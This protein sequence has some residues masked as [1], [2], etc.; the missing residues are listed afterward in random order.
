M[1]VIF[2]LVLVLLLAGLGY[3]VG[4]L[5]RPGTQLV[6]ETKCHGESAIPIGTTT[7]G[8]R[9]VVAEGTPSLDENDLALALLDRRD[10][11]VH[12]R[13]PMPKYPV[14]KFIYV[15]QPKQLVP[16]T[17]QVLL[18]RI[19][20]ASPEGP[21]RVVVWDL[22]RQ[23]EV[24]S[25]T[26]PPRAGLLYQVKASDRYVVGLATAREHNNV[27]IWDR[28]THALHATLR[29]DYSHL[30]DPYFDPTGQRLA[31][32]RFDQ[33]S[34]SEPYRVVIVKLADGKEFQ[35]I[36]GTILSY[37]WL[38]DRPAL[39][40]VRVDSRASPLV[41]DSPL[42]WERFE[43]NG[44]EFA[45]AA[46]PISLARGPSR[47][48]CHEQFAVQST[49]TQFLPWRVWFE[50]NAPSWLVVRVNAL[51]PYRDTFHLHDLETSHYR[52]EID[53]PDRWFDPLIH[54][55]A[56]E[57]TVRD[58]STIYHYR[59]GVGTEW[60]P[61]A[62]AASGAALGLLLTLRRRRRTVAAAAPPPPGSPGS[63]LP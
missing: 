21:A 6:W 61:W 5:L 30:A 12:S 15:T 46:G 43:W 42:V 23:E 45:L 24:D 3:G 33:R 19:R 28:S 34:R 52:H 48:V 50:A 63:P 7:C 26:S 55:D 1:R 59:T 8:T 16:G 49:S 2:S 58:Q 35:H 4:V 9:I 17:N 13:Q 31:F 14:A 53:M 11:R 20:S 27:L 60:W 54:L 36:P 51:A 38:P 41:W 40:T 25:F 10:G 57:I 47:S 62:G 37:H 29:F 22:D 18:S 32:Q 39:A 44:Q 56:N